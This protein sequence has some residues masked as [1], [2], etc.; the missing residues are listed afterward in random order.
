[1]PLPSTLPANLASTFS[2]LPGPTNELLRHLCRSTAG[3]EVVRAAATAYIQRERYNPTAVWRVLEVLSCAAND[4]ESKATR[5]AIATT[6]QELVKA[7]PS[8]N[9]NAHEEDD[10]SQE[11]A[12]NAAEQLLAECR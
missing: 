10:L 8:G 7:L 1:M 4:D 12:L 6:L 5:S 9:H 11:V 2:E 3:V